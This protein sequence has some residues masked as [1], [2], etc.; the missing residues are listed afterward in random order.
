MAHTLRDAWLAEAVEKL[1]PLFIEAGTPIPEK[2]RASIGFPSRNAGR[3]NKQRI[4]ECWGNPS[5]GIPQVSVSPVTDDAAKILDILAH[6][7]VHATVGC[8]CGH[9]GPFKRLAL[10]IGLEG[11]MTATVPGEALAGKLKAIASKLG[12][13]PHV[14][15]D[16]SGRKK[17]TTRMLKAECSPCEYIVR[18]TRK[19]ID[20]HGCPICPACGEQMAE[21]V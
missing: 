17:Q 14:A 4:G 2:V 7:L 12:P 21:S 8:E 19:M 9:R 3:S 1:R 6:E 11:K 15:L 20:T 13:L 18:L 5:D 10:A 16:L